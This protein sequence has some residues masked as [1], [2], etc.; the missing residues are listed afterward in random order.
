MV[1]FSK[2]WRQV[3]KCLVLCTRL[4]RFPRSKKIT[5]CFVMPFYTILWV[6]FLWTRYVCFQCHQ[7]A[8]I[9]KTLY[10]QNQIHWVTLQ[11]YL[12]YFSVSCWGSLFMC[13]PTAL[14]IFVV[15]LCALWDHTSSLRSTYW[16]MYVLWNMYIN[17]SW[18]SQAIK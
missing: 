12:F 9:V 2:I 17:N 7:G 14:V 4:S 3:C 6:T 16:N 18:Y 11:T 15:F 10:I 8:S 5:V 13:E 1:A